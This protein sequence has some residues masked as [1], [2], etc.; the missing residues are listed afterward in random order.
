MKTVV[1]RVLSKNAG[2]YKSG[3]LRRPGSPNGRSGCPIFCDK[4]DHSM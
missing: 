3:G 2:R 4:T 1:N